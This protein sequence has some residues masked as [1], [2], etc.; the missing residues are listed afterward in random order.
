MNNT[1]TTLLIF[2]IGACVFAVTV[3]V[4]YGRAGDRI[5]LL[6]RRAAV[7]S[8]DLTDALNRLDQVIAEC[9]GERANALRLLGL[10]NQ[11]HAENVALTQPATPMP[12]EI[13]AVIE[14]AESILRGAEGGDVR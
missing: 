1:E 8:A 4:L 3:G 5:D 10:L 11:A 14:T 6:Q 13:R 12:G 2:A 9:A 7:R